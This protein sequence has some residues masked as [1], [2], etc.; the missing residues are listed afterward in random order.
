MHGEDEGAGEGRWCGASALPALLDAAP[1]LPTASPS[2]A[3]EVEAAEVE[4][5]EAEAAEAEAAEAEAEAAEAEAAEAASPIR[6]DSLSAQ[7]SC[8]SSLARRE[9]PKRPEDPLA[10]APD[11]TSAAAAAAACTYSPKAAHAAAPQARVP[12]SR[13]PTSATSLAPGWAAA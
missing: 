9:D 2:L 13:E 7:A 4:A 11:A 6:R 10:A 12:L 3:A 5:A 1:L 8:S